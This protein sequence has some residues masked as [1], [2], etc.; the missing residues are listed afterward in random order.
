VLPIC[1]DV[2]EL[3]DRSGKVHL[4]P[5]RRAGGSG[6]SVRLEHSVPPLAFMQTV[7]QE[8]AGGAIKLSPA[9]NFF[10]KFPEAEIELVSLNG[11]CKE[12]TLWFGE[13]ATPGL[14]RATALPAGVTLSGD[15]LEFVSD[16]GALGGYLHDPDA[17]VVRA[18]LLDR[19]CAELGL[20]RL[21]LEEEY[22]TSDEPVDS[23]FVRSFRVLAELPNN[24]RQIRAYFRRSDFGHVEVKCRRIPIRAE[25]V[26]RKLPRPGETPGVLI[27]ARLAG[28]SRAIV[29]TRVAAGG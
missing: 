11:E 25:E 19:A 24:E 7:M 14:W 20:Q 6:R 10:G 17:G 18:G 22:L 13:L 23:P 5:D 3:A 21:D 12:A 2:Q 27:F 4:D 16:V 9:A 8:F 29:C 1:A 15:P 28:K 26:L